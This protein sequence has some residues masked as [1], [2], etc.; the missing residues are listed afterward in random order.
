MIQV[1]FII[2]N[3]DEEFLMDFKELG[4]ISSRW[5]TRSLFLARRY[6]TKKSALKIVQKLSLPY[7]LWV[8]PLYESESQFMLACDDIEVPE[9]LK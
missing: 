8:L 3:R 2:A 9:W 6:S 5:W 4:G 7:R 1:G